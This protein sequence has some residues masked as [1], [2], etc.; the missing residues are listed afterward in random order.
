V[1][2]GRSEL[3]QML[4]SCSLC[5]HGCRVDRTAGERGL[6]GAGM[7]LEVSSFCIHT[8]EEPVL[9]GQAGV[10]N[11]FLARCSLNCVYCQNHTISQP[12]EPEVSRWI[13][14][15]EQLP[16]KLLEMQSAGC[17]TAGFVTPTHYAPQLM[18]A[19]EKAEETGFRIPV[20]YNTAAYDSP[21][22]IRALDGMVDIYLPDLKY[23][24]HSHAEK[25]SEAPGYVKNSRRCL[26]EMYEQVGPL[27]IDGSGVAV[28]GLMVRLLV[29]PGDL[30]GT[31]DSLDFIARDLG[32]DVSVSL[33]SQYYPA[34]RAREFPELDR[35]LSRREYDM[36]VDHLHRLGLEAGWVQDP[37]TSPDSY[38]PLVDFSLE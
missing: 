34:H 12:R 10:A 37:V 32:R 8:G 4:K 30:S 28:R 21:D 9:T 3:H 20:I 16:E 38:R 17:P 26:Q 18:S 31:L 33:M 25:Y 19:L 22:L 2:P 11:V 29:L 14:R 23:S 5:A 1:T 24:S 35:R 27:Q 7:E 6:C 13:R 36:A 15:G